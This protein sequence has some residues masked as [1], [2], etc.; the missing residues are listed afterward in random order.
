V[1]GARGQCGGAAFVL[2]VATT[3]V[4]DAANTYDPVTAEREA[5]LT[6]SGAMAG[7]DASSLQLRAVEGGSTEMIRAAEGRRAFHGLRRF[8]TPFTLY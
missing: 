8:N 2:F 7:E 3:T 5:Q 1:S 6:Y 4:G